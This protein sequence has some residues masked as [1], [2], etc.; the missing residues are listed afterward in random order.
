MTNTIPILKRFYATIF[1][2]VATQI[3]TQFIL[4][5]WTFNIFLYGHAEYHLTCWDDTVQS[6]YDVHC[7]LVCTPVLYFIE[8]A[9]SC[10]TWNAW[11]ILLLDHQSIIYTSI[12][13]IRN[14]YF[15]LS[16]IWSFE[17]HD[18]GASQSQAIS[19]LCGC[20]LTNCLHGWIA[21]WH[22]SALFFLT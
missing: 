22:H 12:Y 5:I 16:F 9:P 13:T 7:L 19:F 15:S 18:L 10:W 6:N 8:K 21:I 20:K 2:L 17:H 11:F 1:Q 4:N 14:K 3:I